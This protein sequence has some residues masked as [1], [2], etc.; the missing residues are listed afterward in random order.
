MHK[1]QSGNWHDMGVVIESKY[2]GNGY[3]TEAIRLLIK[4]AFEQ[5][6]VN[7]I[8]NDFETN[9]K[10]AI[11]AHLSAGFQV[12]SEKDGVITLYI[13]KEQFLERD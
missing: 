9:R 4:E 13:T 1:S 6:Q 8:H 3:A 12:L 7:V 2:R 10:A 5:M 11:K